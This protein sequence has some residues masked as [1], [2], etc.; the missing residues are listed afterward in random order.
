MEVAYLWLKLGHLTTPMQEKP[1][2]EGRLVAAVYLTE[3]SV[4]ITT[5][6]TGGYREKSS[7]L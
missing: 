5:E 3:C 7:R 4:A 2:S 1:E 6:E